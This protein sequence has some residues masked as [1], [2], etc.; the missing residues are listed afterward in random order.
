M[1]TPIKGWPI[2]LTREITRL[3]VTEGTLVRKETKWPLT[4]TAA[5]FQPWFL[6]I[7]EDIYEFDAVAFGML[8]ISEAGKSPAGRTVLLSQ[9][10]NNK[11]HLETSHEP[12][13][14]V[15]TE[16]D[17]LRGEPGNPVMADFLDDG[18]VFVIIFKALLAFTD[19]GLF[20]AMAWA[21]WG[22][23]KWVQK[24]PRGFSDNAFYEI[25][26][27]NE[28]PSLTREEF[29]EVIQPS[30]HQ[31]ATGAHVDAL[32][33]RVGYIV[34]AAGWVAWR[35]A[36]TEHVDVKRKFIQKAEFLTDLGKE[37]YGKYRNNCRDL[38]PNHD[39]LV[40]EEQVW[41]D[42]VLAKNRK[43]R[44]A[45]HTQPKIAGP[46]LF[47]EAKTSK[48]SVTKTI[49]K[50]KTEER[51]KVAQIFQNLRRAPITGTI[52]LGSPSPAKKAR[53]F[54]PAEVAVAVRASRVD[55]GM[56]AGSRAQPADADDNDND[57]AFGFDL[58]ID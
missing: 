9:A 54:D 39:E 53:S 51:I 8:G 40:K 55:A 23:T 10:R 7:L 29:L 21:R 45:K 50:E 46:K 44:E 27:K 57:N 32:L 19:V 1:Y 41:V 56:S 14:R 52:D 22:C 5:H 36:G 4:L 33:K 12:C 11:A 17:L 15:T 13:L 43:R 16:F 28:W 34:V 35:P 6:E 31:Q 20:E 37:W 3:I 24:Q 42:R 58:D 47:E 49:K 48:E 30:I 26:T 2:A 38:P 25:D 18:G